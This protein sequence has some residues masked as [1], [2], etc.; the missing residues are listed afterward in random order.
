MTLELLF[1]KIDKEALAAQVKAKQAA[2]SQELEDERLDL[3]SPT[4]S[5][6][7]NLQQQSLP[8]RLRAT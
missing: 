3:I 1:L 2:R 7:S 8:T 6:S 4:V 5:R